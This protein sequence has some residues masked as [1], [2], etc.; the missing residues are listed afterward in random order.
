MTF[1]FIPI[2]VVQSCFTEKFGIPRQPGLAPSAQ[3]RILLYPEFAQEAAFL[4]LE[5]TSHIWLQFVFHQTDWSGK[6]KVR[7]PRLGGNQSLGV[8][9]TRSPNRPNPIGLSVVTYLGLERLDDKLYIKVSGLDLLD[10]TPILDIK[11]YV[12]YADCLTGAVSELASEAPTIIPVVFSSECADVFNEISG[13]QFSAFVTNA[14]HL[15]ALLVEVLSQDPRPQYQATDTS[16]IYGMNLAGF[17]VR[18]QYR[19]GIL[20]HSEY[21]NYEG[22][23][24]A[25]LEIAPILTKHF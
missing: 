23:Y 1:Q 17:N 3:G 18:W 19:Q 22:V 9:A 4:G 21:V 15:K 10:G 14:T 20:N 5:N 8:F 2:G 12:P 25:V 11:P 16:R 24:I 13:Q 6:L 7:P